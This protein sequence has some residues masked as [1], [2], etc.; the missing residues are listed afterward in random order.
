MKTKF[1]KSLVRGGKRAGARNNRGRITT[2]HRG[3]GN[4]RRFRMVD[5]RYDKTGVPAR[6][7]AI[8]YDPNRTARIAQVLYA[9]GERRYVL[10]PH[11][12]TPGARFVTGDDVPVEAGNR[13]TLRRIPVGTMV[14]GVEL[15]RGKGSQLG[16]SAGVAI[17]VLAH[18]DGFT[19]L[20]LPSGEVRK[21]QWGNAASVGQVGNREH[22]L[23][24]IPKAGSQRH[25]GRRPV[26]RAS[27]MNPRDHSYGGG[28]GRTQRGTKRPKDIWG[29]ITG[30]RKT[31]NKRKA[32]TKLIME[33]R[34]S[35]KRK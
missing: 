14:Y 7:L 1:I 12:A 28:E 8:E 19:H 11:G 4:K 16:R 25:R 20:K 33:R 21:V 13:T 6:I 23:Q 31:R 17:Q 18:E 30:G 15:T 10:A 5:V 26:T 29:N 32:S 35:K 9:D 34:K 24:R 2:R 27:V 22:N 3:G